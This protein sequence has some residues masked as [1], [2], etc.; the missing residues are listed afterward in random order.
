MTSSMMMVKYHYQMTDRHSYVR[1]LG[2]RGRMLVSSM[3]R[4]FG[5]SQTLSRPAVRS[6]ER[7]CQVDFIGLLNWR[8]MFAPHS[9]PSAF[10]LPSHR[11]RRVYSP[12]L[13]YW[14][15]MFYASSSASAMRFSSDGVISS[16]YPIVLRKRSA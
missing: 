4:I 7:P 6:I 14:K 9:K 11:P 8:S 10:P 3:I 16:R 5:G 1:F 13:F 2:I 12:Q 15:S